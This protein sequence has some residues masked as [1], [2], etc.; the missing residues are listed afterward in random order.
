MITFLLNCINAFRDSPDDVPWSGLL[1]RQ[2]KFLEEIVDPNT[3]IAKLGEL[4]ESAQKCFQSEIISYLPDIVVDSQHHAIG[5]ILSNLLDDNS[6]LT[7]VIL[8]CMSRLTLSKDYLE[9]VK[10]KALDL[11]KHNPKLSTLPAT[12]R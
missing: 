11:L 4:L 3:I 2:F 12:T 8:D 10:E 5:E 6:E 9:I 7:A 1:L